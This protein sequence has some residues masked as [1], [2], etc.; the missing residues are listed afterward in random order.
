MIF[1]GQKWARNKIFSPNGAETTRHHM[2]QS[3]SRHRSHTLHTNTKWTM[4]LKVKCKTM[5]LLEDNIGENPDDLQR[6][7]DSSPATPKTWSTRVI[8]EAGVH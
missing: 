3:G 2:Q 7:D 5:R 4:N 8:V 1:V 6:G